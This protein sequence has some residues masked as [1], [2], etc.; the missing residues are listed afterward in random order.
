MKLILFFGLLALSFTSLAQASKLVVA[1]FIVGNTY[2]YTVDN[3]KEDIKDA[4]ATGVDGFALNFGADAWQV[5]RISDAYEAAAS[6][7]TDFKLFLSF[8]MTAMSADADFIEGLIRRF[9]D[10]PNQLRWD[11]KIFVST[12]SGETDNFGRSDVSSGWNSAVK[13]PLE[14]AGCPIFFAPSWTA[15][16]GGALQQS[17]TDGFVSWNTW[18]T[19]SAD[20][21]ANDD[22]YYKQLANSLGKIYVAP[23]SPWF[24]THLQYKNWAYK[25][26]WLYLD[27]LQQMLDVQPDMIEI[28]TW[29]DFGESHY[30]GKIQGALPSGSDDYVNG[31]DHAAWRYMIAPYIAAFKNG[32]SKPYINFESLFYW[33]RP[34]SKYSVPTDDSIGY[35][36]GGDYN[37][38]LIYAAVYLLQPAEI[39]ITCGTNKKTFTGS[40]GVNRFSIS[41][42]PGNSPYFSV[43]RQG[44]EMAS[45]TGP[46]IEKSTNVY[47]FNAYTGTL[48]F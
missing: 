28:L 48:F 19:S 2:P 7:S 41:M 45:K 39:T 8:D 23:L 5:E 27:R 38:D 4:V 18:P 26:D 15:L 21:N 16:G 30:I 29:N 33:Y 11:N 9:A 44:K 6:V 31:F 22:Y 40:P 43:S 20:M 37:E 14:S 46:L 10:K 35:P 3:W 25:S 17:V 34:T 36:S 12:F 1:H 47:N 42:V 32:A 24:F 13:E